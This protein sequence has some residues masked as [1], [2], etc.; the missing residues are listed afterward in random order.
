GLSRTLSFFH[1]LQAVTFPKIPSYKILDV[2][3]AVAPDMEIKIIGIRPG[4]KLHELMIPEDEARHSI[5]FGDHYVIQPDFVWWNKKEHLLD[6]GGKICPDGFSY[7]S[8]T[9]T[10]WLSIKDL[11]K[12]VDEFLKEHP[13][14]R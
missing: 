7:K 12:L 2:A 14:Y 9:N 8:D 6:K 5:E 1:L 10:E 11:K 4:E 13:E 3:K